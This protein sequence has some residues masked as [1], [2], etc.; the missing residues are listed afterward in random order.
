MIMDVSFAI[1]S[2]IVNEHQICVEPVRVFEVFR[3]N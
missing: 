2:M 1:V 3:C